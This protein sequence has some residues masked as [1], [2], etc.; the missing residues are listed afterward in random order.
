MCVFFLNVA[1]REEQQ[2]NH[3][4]LENP[5]GVG[6]PVC[7]FFH[8]RDEYLFKNQEAIKNFFVPQDPH[9]SKYGDRNGFIFP[10]NRA[11]S[12]KTKTAW[13]VLKLSFEGVVDSWG[14]SQKPPQKGGPKKNPT[15]IPEILETEQKNPLRKSARRY[16]N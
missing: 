16:M 9:F 14:R 3:E 4:H 8:R 2:K 1:R 13:S 11:E 7:C 15:E 6:I 10:P 12:L 5:V